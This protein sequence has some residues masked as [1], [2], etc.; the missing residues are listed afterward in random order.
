ML[1]TVFGNYAIMQRL[2]GAMPSIVLDCSADLTPTWPSWSWRL[3]WEIR[4]LHSWY[5]VTHG[6][7]W[8]LVLQQI[9]HRIILPVH[10]RIIQRPIS[11]FLNNALMEFSSAVRCN[12]SR[13]TMVQ[14]TG[15]PEFHYRD[16][17]Y[18]VVCLMLCVLG[19]VILS[20]VCHTGGSVKMVQTKTPSAAWE[21]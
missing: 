13:K 18:C 5:I 20:V 9:L 1:G 21:L 8:L 19:I 16:V 14:Q 4:H 2:C 17:L 15:M 10:L 7:C 11:R 6:S 3:C 12:Y